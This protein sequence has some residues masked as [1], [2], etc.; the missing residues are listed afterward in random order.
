[1]GFGAGFF[2]NIFSEIIKDTPDWPAIRE[3]FIHN[4]PFYT[5]FSDNQW[6]SK[7][8]T[9]ST[10]S[11]Q[12]NVHSVDYDNGASNG[13]VFL[14]NSSDFFSNPDGTPV[15]GGYSYQRKEVFTTNNHLGSSNGWSIEF[16]LKLD[17]SKV[18]GTPD[19]Y[20]NSSRTGFVVN[21]RSHSLNE[22]FYVCIATSSKSTGNG[23]AALIS[24][25]VGDRN[26]LNWCQWMRFDD[27]DPYDG[28]IYTFSY[29]PNDPRTIDGQTYYMKLYIDG[30]YKGNFGAP[31]SRSVQSGHYYHD[32]V[33]FSLINRSENA[34]NRVNG[35]YCT[36]YAKAW[37]NDIF[38]YN[39]PY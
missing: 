34:N 25:Y 30:V 18:R 15:M 21:I 26:A 14:E 8:G 24:S 28:H 7:F 2:Y 20:F 23:S 11:N 10:F 1:M 38:V 33:G 36:A 27:I 4:I 32:Y 22:E 29:E 37:V 19:E 17:M 9:F 3:G 16:Q 12:S 5:R 6:K 13:E 31:T 35:G 39:R